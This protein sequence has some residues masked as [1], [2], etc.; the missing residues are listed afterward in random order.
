MFD[1]ILFDLD[2]TLSDSADGITRCV[3]YALSHFDIHLSQQELTMFVGP[4]LMDMF[5][6]IGLTAEQAQTALRLFRE[7]FQTKGIFEN[8]VYPGIPE[9]LRALHAAGRR[10]A[11]ATS[12]P[13]PFAVEILRRYGVD[14]CFTVIA[15]SLFDG[16]RDTK[17]QVLQEALRQLNVTEA[18][19][20][21]LV[22]VGDRKYDVEGAAELG[23][24]C[25]GVGYGYAEPDEL[26]MAGA[27]FYVPT[28]AALQA[29]LM[30]N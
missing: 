14:S 24:R 19:K 20:D 8:S 9:M 27:D 12:K 1:T 4:P 15:G 10:L 25:I 23:L 3:D 2:G 11:V 6:E 21:R 13:E 17:T 18:Q 5:L 30:N 28:V 22:M 7:R 16:S 26:Q 29:L